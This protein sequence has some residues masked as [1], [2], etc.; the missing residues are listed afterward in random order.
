MKTN[1]CRLFIALT[2]LALATFNSRLSTLYAQGSL[3]PPGAPAPTMKTL[4]QID[5]HVSLAGEKRIDVLG[6][7]GDSGNLHVITNSGSYYLSGNVTASGTK[8]GIKI[9]ANNVTLDL[10]GFMVDG[11]GSTGTVDGISANGDNGTICNGTVQKWT[12]N[13]INCLGS[14]YVIRNVNCLTNGQDGLLGNL[15]TPVNNGYLVSNCH[16]FKNGS[17]GVLIYFGSSKIE[18]CTAIQNGAAD[19]SGGIYGGGLGGSVVNCV[20]TANYNTSVPAIFSSLVTGCDAE[21]NSGDGISGT[22]VTS[23]LAVSNGGKGISGQGDGTVANCTALS[24]NGGGIVAGTSDYS[25]ATVINCTAAQNSI[26]GIIVGTNCTVANCTAHNNSG[27]GIQFVGRCLITG[28]NASA[29]H[30]N[31][32]HVTGTSPNAVSRIDGNVATGNSGA[33]ILWVNDLVVRNSCFLNGVNYSPA[34]GGANTGPVQ[35]ASTASNPWANF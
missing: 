27:D 25:G 14:T 16:F 4:D 8:T 26:G 17:S 35:T 34:V 33:G 2:F 3:T 19:G 1:P 7:A 15:N 18:G 11:T 10:N 22:M 21:D 5:S 28:N 23:C 31:G 9:A 13:G 12:G 30:G 29:N 20:A 6:L 24:N 32:F